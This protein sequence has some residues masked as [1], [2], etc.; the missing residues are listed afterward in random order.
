M[1]FQYM[2]LPFAN[3]GHGYRRQVTLNICLSVKGRSQQ[4]VK[5]GKIIVTVHCTGGARQKV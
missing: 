3:K 4:D 1:L 2:Y 5:C